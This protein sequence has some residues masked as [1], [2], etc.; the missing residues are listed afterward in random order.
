MTRLRSP[1]LRG[2]EGHSLIELL[3][4]SL[5]LSILLLGYTSLF[6]FSIDAWL[7]AINRIE[8][9]QNV[10]GA[11]DIMSL[12]LRS[13]LPA[14]ADNT[15]VKFEAYDVNGSPST[16][17]TDSIDDELQFHAA[18]FNNVEGS[19]NT[20][21]SQDNGTS[22]VKVGYWLRRS[23]TA[24]TLIARGK[25]VSKASNT[26]PTIPSNN[27]GTF[28]TDEFAYRISAFD[29]EYFSGT[30]WASSWLSS[31]QG[32]LPKLIR[33]TMTQQ[34]NGDEFVGSALVAP[35]C[36]GTYITK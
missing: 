3:I 25:V 24:D 22:L 2:S 20:V 17:L 29:M 36:N 16:T 14:Y 32:S 35:R 21:A 13:A 26:L 4:A 1:R 31:S 27:F 19:G 11:I 15:G 6:K 5:I 28:G 30:T 9:S 34:R 23:G 18:T 12:D 7:K 8:R 10:F 33:I